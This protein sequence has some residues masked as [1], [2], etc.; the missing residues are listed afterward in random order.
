MKENNTLIVYGDEAKEWLDF[1]LWNMKERMGWEFPEII[2]NWLFEFVAEV[3]Y[4]LK[5]YPR[6][7]L[8]C[9]DNAYVNGGW[10]LIEDRGW[11]KKEAKE[12]YEEGDLL[13]FDEASGYYVESL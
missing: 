3:G 9:W 4:E 5:P 7:T 10:G 1:A 13:F 6:D 8:W 11:S 12:L 2:V